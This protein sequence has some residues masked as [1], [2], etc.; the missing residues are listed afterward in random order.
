MDS[1]GDLFFTNLLQEG[2]NLDNQFTKSQY[3]NQVSQGAGQESQFSTK[4]ESA[5]KKSRSGNFSKEEDNLLISAWLNTSL[6]AV[7]GNE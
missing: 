7:H 5:T 2:S 3:L 4:K 1:S 6:D